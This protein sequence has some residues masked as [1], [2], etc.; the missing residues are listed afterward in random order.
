MTWIPI[1]I[2]AMVLLLAACSGGAPATSTPASL[3]SVTSATTTTTTTGAT[4]TSIAATSTTTTTT[5]PPPVESVEV[6]FSVGDGSDCSM[7]E[8]FTVKVPAGDDPIE[9]SLAALVGGPTE[10]EAE[11]GASS[12]FSTDTAEVI[13]SISLEDGLL[14]VDFVD[15]RSDLEGASTSCGS[16]TLL[17]Q[18]N[19]TALQHPNVERVRYSVVG[20]CSVFFN[21]LQRQ[22]TE[23]DREGAT[24][25]ELSVVEFALGAGCVPGATQLPDGIWFG[26]LDEVSETTLA[27]D[28]AC[29]FNGAP[30]AEA[31]AQDG[32]ES[33][34]PNDYYVRN[35]TELDRML[36]VAAG[37][38]VV[39][40]PDL[41][42]PATVAR[43]DYASW[44]A[45]REE[46]D[47]QPGVWITTVGGAVTFIE[48]QYVP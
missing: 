6:F 17:S 41:G 23:Y 5:E 1:S 16:E 27:F 13:T 43:I 28:L 45:E 36:E 35:S 34:P 42:D 38:E 30:A 3:T 7:V 25:V 47:S 8:G 21:W 44:L 10:E 19:A 2:L 26:Y 20:S 24:V 9:V 22:C 14:L 39:W 12:F 4:T 15:L 37:T 46:R 48:E 18:L 29:W 32:E 11:A 40:L 33:P 31:A